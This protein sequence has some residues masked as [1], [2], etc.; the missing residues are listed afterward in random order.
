M[1]CCSKYAHAKT[2]VER[3][4]QMYKKKEEYKDQ[5]RLLQDKYEM[6]QSKMKKKHKETSNAQVLMQIK[7]GC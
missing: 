5:I 7:T 1:Q 4:G 3:T 2:K 6:Q